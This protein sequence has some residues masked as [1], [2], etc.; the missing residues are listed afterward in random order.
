MDG[1]RPCNQGGID[2]P[3]DVEVGLRWRV[4]R[5]PH[6]LIGLFDERRRCVGVGV[7]GYRRYCVVAGGAHDTPGYLAPVGNQ[8]P[9]NRWH[10]RPYI[11]KTPKPLRPST[12][13]EWMAERAMPRTVRVS[14]GSTMPSSYNLLVMKRASDSRLIC[15]STACCWALRAF[16]SRVRPVASADWRATMDKTPASCWGPMTA[17]R[18]PGHMNSRRGP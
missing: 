17:T 9:G 13:L 4:T 6:G 16:S 11:R 2:D 5:E 18:A 12:V 14:L 8:E 3:L 1:V 10:G 7:D 15:S